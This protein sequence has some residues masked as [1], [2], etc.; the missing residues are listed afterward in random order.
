[1]AGPSKLDQHED[2]DCCGCLTGNMCSRAWGQW[3]CQWLGH[4]KNILHTS[5]VNVFYMVNTNWNSFKNLKTQ[6]HSISTYPN[7]TWQTGPGICKCH[8]ADLNSMFCQHVLPA[9]LNSIFN[10]MFC[11]CQGGSQIE[12]PAWWLPLSGRHCQLE[13]AVQN[14]SLLCYS[15]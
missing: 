4:A 3:E 7:W 10:S 15:S 2:S 8:H 9:C 14:F 11:H 5:A 12:A 6:S 1:M 13:A